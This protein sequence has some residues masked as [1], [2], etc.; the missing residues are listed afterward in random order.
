MQTAIKT[1]TVRT[2][3][4]PLEA[5]TCRPWRPL[6]SVDLQLVARR[7]VW[8]LCATPQALPVPFRVFEAIRHI[9]AGTVAERRGLKHP[10]YWSQMMPPTDGAD[11]DDFPVDPL[12]VAV[13]PWREQLRNEGWDAAVVEGPTPVGPAL[14]IGFSP[15]MAAS[16]E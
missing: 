11:P 15:K 7:T 2:V 10:R 5:I 13:W 4:L 8:T 12:G 1:T 6:N 3:D 16:A 9:I 14:V